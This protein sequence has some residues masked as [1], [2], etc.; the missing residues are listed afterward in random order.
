MQRKIKMEE[1]VLIWWADQIF[2]E[3]AIFKLRTKI[4]KEDWPGTERGA[5]SI[6]T[7]IHLP[8]CHPFIYSTSIYGLSLIVGQCFKGTEIQK[9]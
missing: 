6:G 3:K 4:Y 7:C 9:Q 1:S 8:V 5:G 2:L